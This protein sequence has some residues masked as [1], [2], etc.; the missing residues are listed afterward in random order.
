[1][2]TKAPSKPDSKDVMKQKKVPEWADG[3]NP[4]RTNLWKFYYTP[5]FRD[6][7]LYGMGTGALLFGHFFYQTRNISKASSAFTFGL[8]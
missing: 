8:W 4:Y 5:C 6:S 7:I 2:S 3:F 1:M